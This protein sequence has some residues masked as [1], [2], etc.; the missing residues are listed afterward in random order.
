MDKGKGAGT[1]KAVGVVATIGIMTAAGK[2]AETATEMVEVADSAGSPAL[3]LES[4]Q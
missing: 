4:A 1:M 2:A 3:C